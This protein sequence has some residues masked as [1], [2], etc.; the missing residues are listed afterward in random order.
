MKIKSLYINLAASAIII[1]VGI[2]GVK[3][4]LTSA[5]QAEKQKPSI[6]GLMVETMLLKPSKHALI[7][8]SIGTVEPSQKATLSSKVSGKIVYT[9]PSF[10]PGG[11]FKKGEVLAYIDA[12]D[13]EASLSQIDAQLRSAKASEQ[14]ELGQQASAKKELELS[15]LNPNGL[16][17]SL[18]L[19]EPQLAQVQ[20]T[21]AGLE[22]SLKAAQN[23]LKETRIIAP[24]DGIVTKKSAEL[25]NYISAQSSVAEFVSTQTFWL[26][27]TIPANY[28]SLLN[29]PSSK[30]LSSLH[31]TLFSHTKPLKTKAHV[32][33]ILPE[34]DTTTK[35]ARLLISIDEPLAK[36]PSSQEI[37]LG[38]TLHVE[39]QAG[40]LDES[41]ALPI[42]FLRANSTV[43]VM[44]SSQK[45]SM[46]P[47]EIAYKN[48]HFAFIRKGITSEDK[49]ITSYLTTA[50]EGMALIDASTLKKAKK[51]E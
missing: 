35:Q 34:L 50:V 7:I 14:M 41:F 46:R 51:G 39:I 3:Y 23:N 17:R 47:V 48:E 6:N 4:L 31:V 21:I 22:A 32:L 29:A 38:D 33:K 5:P 44:D 12:S 8:P 28:L 20:A 18:I 49:I 1:S 25:G 19:R 43:W 2:L 42:Q 9:A 24:Y 40:E 10:V 26:Y 45:L 15:G 27:A 37:L 16:S 30:G 13:Y 11:A 36:Q